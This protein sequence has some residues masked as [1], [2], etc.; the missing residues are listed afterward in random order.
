MKTKN[1][2]SYTLAA[3]LVGGGLIAGLAGCA[4]EGCGDKCHKHGDLA[5]QAKVSRADAEAAALA[6]VPG[7]TI[8]DGELEKEHGKLIWSFDITTSDSKDITE[9]AVCAMSGKVMSV[10]KESPADQAKEAAEDA[11]KAKKEKGEEKD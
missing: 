4:S 1:I 8:K 3:L 10:D 2:V 11:A 5:A 7:G 6:K 9:V